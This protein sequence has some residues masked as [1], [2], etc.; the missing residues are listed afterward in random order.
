MFRSRK[1]VDL[2]RGA[3]CEDGREEEG[4]GGR[5][6]WRKGRGERRREGWRRRS[7]G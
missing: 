1:A 5:W 6:K 4:E 7:G 3:R 2:L